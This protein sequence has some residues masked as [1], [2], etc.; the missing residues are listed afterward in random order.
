MIKWA[1]SLNMKTIQYEEKYYQTSKVGPVPT[2]DF[3]K[4]G[5]HFSMGTM[6]S[7]GGAVKYPGLPATLILTI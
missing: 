6:P 3:V 5:I 2:L 7:L 1:I 4:R